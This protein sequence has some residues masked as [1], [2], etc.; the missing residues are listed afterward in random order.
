MVA[1]ALAGCARWLA[2]GLAV[3][4]QAPGQTCLVT[5]GAHGLHSQVSNVQLPRGGARGAITDLST[6][7]HAKVAVTKGYL[8]HLPNKFHIKSSLLEEGKEE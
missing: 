1:Q 3:P 2:E 7:S 8:S 5:R 6:S 4:P